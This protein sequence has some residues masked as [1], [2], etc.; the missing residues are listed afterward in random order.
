MPV[1]LT[2]CAQKTDLLTQATGARPVAL[3][4]DCLFSKETNK[5]SPKALYSRAVLCG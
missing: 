1:F 2:V 5:Y 4:F 3:N